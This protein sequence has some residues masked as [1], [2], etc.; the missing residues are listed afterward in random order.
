MPEEG[1]ILSAAEQ[2]RFQHFPFSDELF[3][4]GRSR[5]NEEALRTFYK[6]SGVI[7]PRVCA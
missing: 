7:G 2:H 3:A 6:T 5:R 1:R 4:G